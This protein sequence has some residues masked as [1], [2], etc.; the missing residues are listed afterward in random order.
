MKNFYEDYEGF[1]RSR[2]RRKQKGFRRKV[3]EAEE[4]QNAIEEAEGLD[5]ISGWGFDEE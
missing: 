3:S 5:D 1:N 2:G 4:I